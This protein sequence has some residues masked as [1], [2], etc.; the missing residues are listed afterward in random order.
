M[1]VALIKSSDVEAGIL[2]GGESELSSEKKWPGAPL[3][4][5]GTPAYPARLR[6]E[7]ARNFLENLKTPYKKTQVRKSQRSAQKK[8]HVRIF[9]G[10]MQ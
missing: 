8:L 7:R 9:S 10:Q 2:T 4:G 3:R 5:R 1:S 6:S